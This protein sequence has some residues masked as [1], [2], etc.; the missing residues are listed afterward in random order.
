[1]TSIKKRIRSLEE[2]DNVILRDDHRLVEISAQLRQKRA[3]AIAAR[4]SMALGVLR[5]SGV[6]ELA[7]GEIVALLSSL[8]VPEA[9]HSGIP[10]APPDASTAKAETAT[11]RATTPRPAAPKECRSARPQGPSGSTARRRFHRALAR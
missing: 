10:S 5:D 1:M 9:E 11:E 6:L 3:D 2:L 4:E 7:P 8:K